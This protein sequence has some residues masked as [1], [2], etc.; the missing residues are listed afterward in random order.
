MSKDEL[1][2]AASPDVVPFRA[3]TCF[4]EATILDQESAVGLVTLA[5]ICSSGDASTGG[6]WAYVD[7]FELQAV[8]L[9]VTRIPHE[10]VMATAAARAIADDKMSGEIHVHGRVVGR[11]FA[12]ATEVSAFVLIQG[13][14]LRSFHRAR[15]D[16][17]N[18]IVAKFGW[19]RRLGS[20]CWCL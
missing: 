13:S 17:R 11:I 10:K 3:V 7:R 9:A 5:L 15:V 4:L 14:E 20:R 16:V 19:L 18:R 1:E 8:K 6:V 2:V 12:E